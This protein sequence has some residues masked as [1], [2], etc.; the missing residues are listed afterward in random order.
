M[1]E[2]FRIWFETSFNVVYLAAIWYL[3]IAMWRNLSGVNEKD[4]SVA[5]LFLAAFALLAVGDTGHV[6]FRVLALMIDGPQTMISLAGQPMLLIGLGTLV[7]SVTVTIFYVMMLVIWQRR[8]DKPYGW[9]GILLFGMAIIRL[10]MM[11]P[12]ANQWGTPT[13]PQPWTTYRNLPLI[14]L[15]LG[16]AY[17]ILRD[18][19]KNQD[20]TFIWIGWMIV[21][22]YAFY[23][24][25][26][27]F[28]QKV[29]LLGMLMI[30]KTLAYL[31]AA[32]IGYKALFKNA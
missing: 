22:S 14:I 24:P 13:P 3:V 6:G 26:I 27:L 4:R 20:R 28:V 15:G 7:T 5:Q 10:V 23:I 16:S 31:A 11:M 17:L 9:L 29:P 19:Y 30:P 25:V 21:I 8:F 1:P 32:A 2:N 18:A 12:V